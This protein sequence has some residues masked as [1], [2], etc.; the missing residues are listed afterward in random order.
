MS[1][2]SSKSIAGIAAA[3][4]LCLPVAAFADCAS[5]AGTHGGRFD[6]DKRSDVRNST[7]PDGISGTW[8]AT[9][10]GATC[11]MTGEVMSDFT[12][13]VV[14]K[15]IYNNADGG[16]FR[17]LNVTMDVADTTTYETFSFSTDKAKHLLHF[18]LIQTADY[19]YDGSFDGK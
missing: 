18:V 6:A 12:G 11:E 2:F 1:V 7:R 5:V 10:D 9:V 19:E 4:C 15:G 8:T 14:L 13:K 17:V 16:K 3:V